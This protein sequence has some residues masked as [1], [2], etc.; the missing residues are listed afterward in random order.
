LHAVAD[1]ALRLDG[2]SVRFEDRTVLRDV[3]WAVLPHERWVILGRNGSG[4]ST[5]L[6][7]AS[8]TLHPSQ[9]T[10]DVLGERLGRT[11]VRVLRRRIGV[12]S[13]ALA[14]RFRPGVR[15]REVVMTARY[16]A[17]ETWWHDYGDTDRAAAGKLLAQ[18]GVGDR[19]DQPFGTLSSGERQRVLLARTLLT[20]PGLLLLDEP[21]AGLDLGGREELV[22]ALAALAGDPASPPAVLVTHHVE[23]IPPGFTHALLL[24]E[25]EVHAAGPLGETLTTAALS[26]CFNLRLG[27]ERHGHRW[28]ARAH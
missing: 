3:T 17:L 6:R 27:L 23:E 8:L 18:L 25:G 26:S 16:A 24:R 7:V 19:A 11:D 22:S 13:A 4:K 14:D 10:V 5:L 12:T 2:V 20:E 21:T 9:G 28:S 15:A 1:P